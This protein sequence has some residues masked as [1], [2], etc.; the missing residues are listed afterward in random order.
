MSFI[1]QSIVYVLN[2]TLQV[3]IRN[4]DS[5]GIEFIQFVYYFVFHGHIINSCF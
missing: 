2:A 4:P 3:L 5:C 1:A